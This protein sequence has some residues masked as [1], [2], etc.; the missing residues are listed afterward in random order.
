M[1]VV[2]AVSAYF[3]CRNLPIDN[4]LML[5][6]V[7]GV[8]TFGYFIIAWFFLANDYEKS[9]ILGIIKKSNK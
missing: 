7:I 2:Y 9:L 6:V 5:F 8:Y 4:W 1:I 3:I